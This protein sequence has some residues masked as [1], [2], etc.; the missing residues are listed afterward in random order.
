[1]KNYRLHHGGSEHDQGDSKSLYCTGPLDETPPLGRLIVG[2]ERQ[3]PAQELRLCK[4]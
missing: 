4:G 1:M 3:Q 2:N